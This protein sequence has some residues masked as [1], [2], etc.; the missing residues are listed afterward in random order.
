M[1]KKKIDVGR[2]PKFKNFNAMIGPVKG[3]ERQVIG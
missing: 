3:M 1:R 2:S